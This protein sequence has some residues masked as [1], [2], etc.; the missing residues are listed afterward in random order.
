MKNSFDASLLDTGA[1]M[2]RGYSLLLENVGKTVAFITGVVV[3]LV[4][5]TEIGFL[6]FRAASFTT[7]VL[8][9][10]LASYI[11]YF[12]LEDAGEKLGRESEE[13]RRSEESYKKAKERLSGADITRLREFLSS[14]SEEELAFRRRSYLFG[15]GYSAADY[16]AYLGGARPSKRAARI[17]GKAKKM[18]P[19]A[20]TPKQLLSKER[21][22]HRSELSNP[23]GRKLL[24]LILKLIPT[25]V[26]MIFTVS[27]M[28]GAKEGMTRE[29]IIESILKLSALP[30]IGLRGYAE[31]Y[32]YAKEELPLWLDTKTRLIDAFLR[33]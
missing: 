14:Y 25:T 21:F 16:E 33:S 20:I 8:V 1:A 4:T 12:S 9:M 3:T 7:T 27:L 5:F 15:F 26:C 18:K 22:E 17:F 23:E 32:R 28:L 2:K 13:Y 19:V 6:D 11:I 24:R 29:F 10:L 30:I 31:G